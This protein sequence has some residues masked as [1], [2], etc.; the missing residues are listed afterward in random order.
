[1]N[2]S[3]NTRL[4]ADHS[5]KQQRLFIALSLLLS[6]F[7]LITIFATHGEILDL[8]LF[9]K[10][11]NSFQDFFSHMLYSRN[12]KGAYQTTIHANHPPFY[13]LMSRLLAQMLPHDP[14]AELEPRES[15]SYALFMYILYCTLFGAVL[16]SE[17]ERAMQGRRYGRLLFF[18]IF[19]SGTFFYAIER[20]NPALTVLALLL[21]ALRLKDAESMI[22]R[23]LALLLFAA[24]F[25]IK[26]YTLFFS[27]LYLKEKRFAEFIR[28]LLYAALLFL[29]PLL[30]F[31]N[32]SDLRLMLEHAQKV[33]P[34]TRSLFGI[35]RLSLY[36]LEKLFGDASP[37]LSPLSRFV[38]L[39]YLAFSLVCFFLSRRRWETIG[40]LAL[41]CFIFPTWSGVYT[42]IYMV[43][44]LLYYFIEPPEA[45]APSSPSGKSRGGVV[46]PVAF[47]LVFS[48]TWYPL[49]FDGSTIGHLL[50]ALGVY[51]V[52]FY[53]W[54]D[55]LRAARGLKSAKPGQT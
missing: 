38:S 23:E 55:I 14:F 51:I 47:A 40:S 22:S 26:V 39:L 1:M 49:V 8:Y 17:I 29:I 7:G 36:L 12:L 45:A 34:M 46:V 15:D 3:N 33:V 9:D 50:E 21:I 53:I 25:N 28:Y 42:H 52:Q 4:Q 44:P 6:A 27:L 13:M 31:F 5:E 18:P 32:L 24:C 20:G 54:F 35:R 19:F 11:R 2:L 43:L 16:Y 10:G 48:L 37:L 41:L 30:L